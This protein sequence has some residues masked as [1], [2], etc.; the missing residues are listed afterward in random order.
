MTLEL[1]IIHENQLRDRMLDALMKDKNKYYFT[2]GYHEYDFAVSKNSW[3]DLEMVSIKD[4]QILGYM[5]AYI[6]RQ[7]NH[8]SSLYII[9]LGEFNYTFSKDLRTFICDLFENYNFNKI[10]FT[11]VIGNP[12]EKMYDKYVKQYGG[13]IV[14]YRKNEVKLIDG[15]LYDDK[16]YEITKEDYFNSIK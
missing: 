14:G 3:N 6:R 2:N 7:S 13:R 11:V 8:I 1:A 16:I 9:N 10:N 12:I 15:K 5:G 4:G